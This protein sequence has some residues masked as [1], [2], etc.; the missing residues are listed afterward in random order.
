MDGEVRAVSLEELDE[1]QVLADEII[2][3][4][5]TPPED[6]V[7]NAGNAVRRS[8]RPRTA[9]RCRSIEWQ[10]LGFT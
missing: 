8:S 6:L 4:G 5:E 2:D 3:A 10:G 9:R 7:N 1:L